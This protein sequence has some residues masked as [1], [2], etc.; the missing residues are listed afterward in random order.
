MKHLIET[1]DLSS[2]TR[3]DYNRIILDS[4]TD[5]IIV[6]RGGEGNP[7]GHPYVDLGLSVKWATMNVGATSETEVGHLFMWGS[8]TPNTKDE[9]NW[10]NA[11]FNGGAKTFDEEYFN[12]QKS[13]WLDDND[14]LKLK[15]DAARAIMG[16]DWRMPTEAEY[17]ELLDNTTHDMGYRYWKLTSKKDTSKYIIIPSSGAYG[18][19]VWSSS[20]NTAEPIY[21]RILN[22]TFSNAIYTSISDRYY[23]FGV[24][25]V[26]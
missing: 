9:S 17:Q 12:A 14:N 10:A 18:D 21:A 15:Y 13:E 19:S 2:L 3:V 16:G 22:F 23:S 25:G 11:P 26:L 6:R 1:K 20:L 5:D 8:T 7:N 24:R 4:G